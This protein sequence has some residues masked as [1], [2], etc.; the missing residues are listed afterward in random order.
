[1]PSGPEWARLSDQEVVLLARG[2]QEAAYRELIR[3]YE[4]LD[5]G[6][7]EFD[8]GHTWDG[9]P[10]PCAVGLAVLDLL[11]ERGLV[12]RV[13]ERGPALRALPEETLDALPVTLQARIRPALS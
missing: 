6:S 10:L 8:L 12:D 3:R 2:G 13:R 5:R 9:A 1:M 11:V 7:R 4:A